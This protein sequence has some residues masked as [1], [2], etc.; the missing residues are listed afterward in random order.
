MVVGLTSEALAEGRI[1]FLLSSSMRS[2]VFPRDAMRKRGFCCR[3]VS[4]SP[5]VRLSRWCIVSTRLKI[6][7]YFL[8]R[9][10]SPIIL[11]ASVPKS[12]GNPFSGALTTRGWEKC[13]IFDC[14]RKQY[15]R[16]AH[17]CFVTS[18]GSHRWRIDPCQFR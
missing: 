7:S 5:S 10:G 2:S 9:P 3:P 17:G 8:S 15:T 12:K 11:V 18:I 4:V 6:S 16:Y 14:N 1:R 13:A